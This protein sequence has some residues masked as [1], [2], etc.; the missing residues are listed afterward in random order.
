[1]TQALAQDRLTRSALVRQLAELTNR[2]HGSTGARL[3]NWLGERVDFSD[4]VT[5]ARAHLPAGH[6][7]HDEPTPAASSV[8]D[9]FLEVRATLLR[10]LEKSYN[11]GGEYVRIKLPAAPEVISGREAEAF[12]VYHRF[13]SAWQREID[14]RV[15]GLRQRTASALASTAPELAQLAALDGTIA[16]IIAQHGRKCFSH[17]PLLLGERFLA[18]HDPDLLAPSESPHNIICREMRS[19]LHAEIEARLL[20][21]LGLVEALDEHLEQI[22]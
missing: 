13:Y 14:F 1:M 6:H 7:D 17:A 12:A 3:D 21:V 5:L 18:L 15:Q 16:E 22:S 9:D 11:P 19:L 4:S 8:K 20:P 10:N 2:T